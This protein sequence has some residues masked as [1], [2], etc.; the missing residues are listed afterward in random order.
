MSSAVLHPC[1]HRGWHSG[2]PNVGRLSCGEAPNACG[3]TARRLPQPTNQS[4]GAICKRRDVVHLG[5]KKGLQPRERRTARR[6]LLAVVGQRPLR[7]SSG[8]LTHGSLYTAMS[9]Q[10]GSYFKRVFAEAWSRHKGA[11]LAAYLVPLLIDCTQILIQVR[12]GLMPTGS[13]RMLI[14]AILESYLPYLGLSIVLQIILS[15]WWIYREQLVSLETKQSLLDHNVEERATRERELRD[16]HQRRLVREQRGH[17]E[18]LDRLRQEIATIRQRLDA[19]S[20]DVAIL[21]DWQ[22]YAQRGMRWEEVPPPPFKLKN[23]GA[24]AVDVQIH[25]FE[26]GDKTATFPIVPELDDA[27]EVVPMVYRGDQVPTAMSRALFKQD[28]LADLIEAAD[29]YREFDTFGQADEAVGERPMTE[30]EREAAIRAANVRLE[31]SVRLTYWNRSGTRQWEK[32][33]TLCFEPDEN[34]AYVRHGASV[35]VRTS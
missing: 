2:A 14:L 1:V 29:H 23:Y 33:E 7:C 25:P 22:K 6:Q 11:L 5:R 26:G 18:E 8:Y 16:A 24:P 21:F 19:D 27:R 35:E 3:H 10:F 15:A 28:T 34:R 32:F 30:E 17:Q 4:A 31:I 13:R 20:P 9:R 12:M